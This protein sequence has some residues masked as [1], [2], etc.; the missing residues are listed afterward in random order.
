MIQ[1]GVTGVVSFIL[2]TQ[3][4]FSFLVLGL[5]FVGLSF[6]VPPAWLHPMARWVCRF[7]LLMAG[8]RVRQSGCFPPPKD[9]PYMYL[10]NHTSLLDTFIVICLIPEF[11]GA[12]GKAEQFRIPIWGWV[13]R[14][15]GAVPI[16]RSELRTAIGQLGQVEAA[17]KGGRSLLISPEGTRSQDG[18][19]L[20]FKKG[21][22]HV[23]QNTQVTI[24][25]M[26][27]CGAYRAKRKSS[28]RLHPNL[29]EVR[30]GEPIRSSHTAYVSLDTL[31]AET[32]RRI[33]DNLPQDQR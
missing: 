15:W 21:P 2:W 24:V 11:T 5:C 13:L 9:G 22:F 7:V 1:R 6:I 20:P 30:I 12:I 17:I 16:N 27:I 4:I 28:W 32:W 33:A 19:M 23:A 3:S 26:T 25:P 14:R 18:R 10:F 31:S 8:Q 29:I